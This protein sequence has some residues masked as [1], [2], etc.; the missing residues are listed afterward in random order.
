MFLLSVFIYSPFF[1]IFLSLC[2]T[3]VFL[4]YI[5]FFETALQRPRLQTT[6]PS[7]LGSRSRYKQVLSL[8]RFS[9]KWTPPVL[10]VQP[11][12]WAGASPRFFNPM[13]LSSLIPSRLPPNVEV[14]PGSFFLPPPHQVSTLPSRGDRIFSQ[15]SVFCFSFFF[16]SACRSQS[17]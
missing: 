5:F 14:Q 12:S 16:F 8:P 15:S 4:N 1:T 3:S 7:R 9:A 2:R 6:P 11:G 17:Y 10:G 13:N